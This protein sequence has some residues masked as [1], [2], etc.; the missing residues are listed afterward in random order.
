MHTGKE[1]NKDLLEA[2]KL[3]YD[4]VLAN[5]DSPL[6]REVFL[7]IQSVIAEAEGK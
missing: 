6:S 4:Y 2:L 1:V 7:I 5:Q 3:V